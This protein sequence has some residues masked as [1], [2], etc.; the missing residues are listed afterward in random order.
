MRPKSIILLVLALGCGLVASI[1]INQLMADRGKSAPSG[2]TV[3]IF[4]AVQDINMNDPVTQEMLKLEPW[5]KDKLQPGALVKLDQIV[6]R[7]TKMRILAGEPILEGKLLATGENGQQGAGDQIPAGMR[8]VAVKSDDVTSTGSLIRPGDRVDV[9]VHLQRNDGRGI[10]ETTS[11]TFLRD[12]KI[13]AVNDEFERSPNGEGGKIT[14]KTVTLLVLPQQAELI[15]L[16]TELGKI[17]LVMRGPNDSDTEESPGVDIGDLTGT[18]ESENREA[19]YA[20]AMPADEDPLKGVFNQRSTAAVAELGEQFTMRLIRG[21]DVEEMVF[22]DGKGLP[23]PAGSVVE[24]PQPTSPDATGSEDE[25]FEEPQEDD[26]G[27]E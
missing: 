6:G 21:Q 13:F 26:G 10:R 15:S 23:Q 3:S 11:R 24:E 1:G 19:E 8:A 4:V 12:I 9:V 25:E 7:R 18:D 16:A 27:D 17:R 20:D 2:E 14:A 5:P 22:A